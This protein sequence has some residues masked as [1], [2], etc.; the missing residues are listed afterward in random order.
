MHKIIT[1]K[2]AAAL[3]ADNCTIAAA[4]QGLSGWPQEIALAIGESFLQTGHPKNITLI[5]S[6]ACG[7]HQDSLIGTGAIAYEGLIGRLICAHTGTA[8]RMSRLVSEN[9]AECYLLPQGIFTH[10]YKSIAGNKP[11]VITKVGLHTFVDPRI[12]GGKC[13]SITK[14]D[15]V[16]LI[17]IDGEQWLRYKNFVP[18]VA[19]LRGTCCDEN[20][21][22]TMDEEIAFLEQLSIASAVKTR[23]GIVICQVKYIAA[24]GSL[25]PKLVKIPGGLIDYI[26]VASCAETH[27]QTQQ[28]KYNPVFSGDIR[29]PEDKISP[30]PLDERKVIAR[31]A[32]MELSPGSLVNLGIG[33]PL[34]VAAV[35]SEEGVSETITMTTEAGSYGGTPAVGLDFGACYNP[36][37]IIENGAMFDLYDGGA[38][39][40]AFLGMAQ[41]D[42]HGNVNV[43][44]LGSKLNGP[45]GFINISQNTK[46]VIFCATFSIGAKISICNGLLEIHEEGKSDKFVN[47]V[48]Q[49][50]F[51]GKYATQTDQNILFITE[52]CVFKLQNQKL[53]LTEIAPGV[54][55]KAQ[56][57]DLIPFSP[58]VSP[59]IKEMD[60]SLFW[61]KWDG[62]DVLFK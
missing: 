54:D 43:S 55:L 6:S 18:D 34:G 53:V 19:L 44:K 27:M 36:E 37:A 12:E 46:N 58:E 28:T 62:L 26:V 9:K 15:I 33:I 16:E 60:A 49:I 39:D 51:S 57:L 48:S 40:A 25:H 32:A 42:R 11:G 59:H 14:E 24:N 45:G 7:D 29:I 22:M 23:G 8:L 50:T 41:A 52:R 47:D 3:I 2:Q 31:R 56:I 35:L 13:N 4:T 10:I 30:L 20:G 61:E 1:A 38:L 21:N 5:H 17:E